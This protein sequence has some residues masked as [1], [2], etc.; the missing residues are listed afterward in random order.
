MLNRL[1]LPLAPQFLESRVIVLE[2]WWVRDR[3]EESIMVA[4]RSRYVCIDSTL[5]ID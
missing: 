5:L 3:T 1:L 2:S 4:K